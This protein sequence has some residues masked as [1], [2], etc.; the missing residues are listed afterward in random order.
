MLC[1]LLFQ[2]RPEECVYSEFRAED[3][4]FCSS[5][6]RNSRLY[7]GLLVGLCFLLI[8]VLLTAQGRPNAAWPQWNFCW[9]K[10]PGKGRF[11]PYV[12]SLAHGGWVSLCNWDYWLM[13]ITNARRGAPIINVNYVGKIHTAQSGWLEKWHVLS[14]L[15]LEK[16]VCHG[17]ACWLWNMREQWAFVHDVQ[18]KEW[19]RKTTQ[20]RKLAQGICSLV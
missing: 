19:E 6:M 20:R 4:K 12:T 13:A 15:Q 1:T 2:R 14:K 11:I 8:H 10:C 18:I 7:G 17:D 5:L 16:E 9:C 3:S